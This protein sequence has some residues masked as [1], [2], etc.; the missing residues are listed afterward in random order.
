[1]SLKKSKQITIFFKN[2]SKKQQ[3]EH[4]QKAQKPLLFKDI[5]AQAKKRDI[6]VLFR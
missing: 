5:T 4:S 2:L 1:M 3:K 6:D